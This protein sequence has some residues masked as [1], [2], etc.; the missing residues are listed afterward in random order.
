MLRGESYRP[1]HRPRAKDAVVSN[2]PFP[3]A[4][5][6]LK[7]GKTGHLHRR[8]ICRQREF[9][10][11]EP[12][13]NDYGAVCDYLIAAGMAADSRQ[14]RLDEVTPHAQNPPV[15]IQPISVRRLGKIFPH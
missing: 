1:T 2:P 9:A 15:P 8:E 13:P 7:R 10:L 14:L 11:L 12:P 6:A 3:P 4:N 5:L